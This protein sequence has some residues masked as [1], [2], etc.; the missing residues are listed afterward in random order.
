MT[1]ISIRDHVDRRW[2]DYI[3]AQRRAQISHSVEDGIAAGK[4]WREWLNLF[5]TSEQRNFVEGSRGGVIG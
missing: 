2:N 1:V 3:E 4:A 5:M